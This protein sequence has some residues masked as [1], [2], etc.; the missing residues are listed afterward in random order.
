MPL[1]LEVGRWTNKAVEEWHCLICNHGTVEDEEHFLS[2]CKF[3]YD[4]HQD[5]YNYMNN[6]IPNFKNLSIEQKLQTVITKEYVQIFIRYFF[7]I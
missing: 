5:F 7:L 1:Q 4:E 6:N 2:H 3:Y